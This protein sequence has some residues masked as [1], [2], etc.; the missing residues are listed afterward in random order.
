MRFPYQQIRLFQG[1][2]LLA[3]L[4]TAAVNVPRLLEMYHASDSGHPYQTSSVSMDVAKRAEDF[5]GVYAWPQDAF[6]VL[7]PSKGSGLP[8]EHLPVWAK[9]FQLLG[10][11][12]GVANAGPRHPIAIIFDK[13]TQNGIQHVVKQG[14]TIIPN[15]TV[16]R[17]S[18]RS[19]I[20][21][22]DFS[23]EARLEM[24]DG[25]RA[26]MDVAAK[27]DDSDRAIAPGNLM[28]GNASAAFGGDRYPDADKWVFDR[29]RLMAYYT[30]LRN[31]PERMLAVFD[32]MKPVYETDG[33]IS[34]YRLAIEGEA[35]FFD[36]VGLEPGDIV[37]SVNHVPMSSRLHAEHFISRVV[38]DGLDTIAMEVEREGDTRKFVYSISDRKD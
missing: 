24:A 14:D 3:L 28:R 8:D 5:P 13:D 38:A 12:L 26:L 29:Q 18:S 4:L 17:I 27:T 16:A 37:R 9:R 32:S 35:D 2:M 23:Q 19:V 10:T 7:R 33:R 15:I 31:N 11:V 22:G 30:E 20:L 21:R 1:F 36:A 25:R 34:G 6:N